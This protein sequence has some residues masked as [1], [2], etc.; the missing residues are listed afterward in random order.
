MEPLRVGFVGCG[1]HARMSLYPSLRAAFG[2]SPSG[3][4]ALV[5][6]QEER[7]EPPLLAEL[8]ALADHKRAVAERVAAF[9]HVRAVYTDHLSMLNAERLD[10]MIVCMHPRRQAQVAIDCL[11]R[12]VHVWVEKPPAETLR[13]S[14]A[15]AEAARR[16]GKHVAVGYMKRFSYAYGQAKAFMA[17]PGF[18]TPSFYEAR[19]TYGEYPVD[20]YRFLNGFATHHLDLPR[21][22]VGE[23]ESVYAA[24]VHR[25]KGRDGYAVTLRFANGGLGLLNLNCLEEGFNGWSERVVVTGIGG[26]V[27]VENWR[28]VIGF[29]PGEQQPYYWEP[30]DVQPADDQNSLAVHGFVGELREFVESIREGR[31]PSC[32]IDDGIAAV[33]LE[34][35]IER[36]IRHRAEIPLAEVVDDGE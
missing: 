35:A 10:A 15:L 33:R 8:V 11:E 6:T 36:S 4:P 9:H 25:G 24:L 28:R 19:C 17:R 13:E 20:V 3:L 34:R 32:S 16:V 30:E 27:F 12:G 26:R 22:F 29:L 5:L 21:F 14:L 18:G 1:E 23:I 7:T 31:P 2:G